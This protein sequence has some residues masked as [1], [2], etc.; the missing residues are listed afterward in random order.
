MPIRIPFFLHIIGEFGAATGFFLR[1][2]QTLNRPQ[3]DAHAVIRQYALLLTSTNL[4][5]AIFLFQS[6]PTTVSTKVAGALALYH[7]GPLTRAYLKAR[8]GERMGIWE[9]MGGAWVHIVFHSIVTAALAWEAT[10]LL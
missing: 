4:I 1:P 6:Q 2:S 9:G 7:L 8:R 10:L 3:P 5:A